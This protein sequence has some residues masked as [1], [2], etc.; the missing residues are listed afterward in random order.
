MKDWANCS[1]RTEMLKIISWYYEKNGLGQ[2]YLKAAGSDL[3][4]RGR[5]IAYRRTAFRRFS[6]SYVTIEGEG[7][8]QFGMAYR[9]VCGHD[10]E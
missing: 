4:R 8:M 10:R 5:K 7:G 9:N 1:M 3:M 2:G 6:D